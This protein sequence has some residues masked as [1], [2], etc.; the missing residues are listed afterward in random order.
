MFN[1]TDVPVGGVEG[2][3]DADVVATAAAGLIIEIIFD[4]K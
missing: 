1:S 3:G 4:I 2:T